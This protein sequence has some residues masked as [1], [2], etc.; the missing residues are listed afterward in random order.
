MSEQRVDLDRDR[1]ESI[2]HD[3][4]LESRVCVPE[5]VLRMPDA[6]TG[7]VRMT[8]VH[9]TYLRN[10]RGIGLTVW[11]PEG[12]CKG[13]ILAR[14]NGRLMRYGA[15]GA[16]KSRMRGAGPVEHD[17]DTGHAHFLALRFHCG[18]DDLVVDGSPEQE[19]YGLGFYIRNGVGSLMSG[20]PRTRANCKLVTVPKRLRLDRLSRYYL[21]SDEASEAPPGGLPLYLFLVAKRDIDP[22]EELTW[23][24]RIPAGCHYVYTERDTSPP[25]G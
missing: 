21:P 8:V 9:R 24:Y 3:G 25:V 17:G 1:G 19:G 7:T 15:R 2:A 13:S 23:N 5:E 14:Y 6:R 4:R 12:R 18:G 22:G 20:V 16:G 10:I 11:T